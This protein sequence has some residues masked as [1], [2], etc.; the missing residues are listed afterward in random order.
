MFRI[1]T[2]ILLFLASAVN[3][4][5]NV[6]GID[7]YKNVPDEI[8]YRNSFEREKWFYEQRIF[9]NSKFPAN[10]YHNALTQKMNMLNTAGYYDREEEW[11][12]IGPTPAVNIYYGN[13]SSRIVSVKFHPSNPDIIYIAAAYGGVWKSTNGGLNWLPKTDFEVTLSSGALAID[14]TNPEIIYYGTGEA[15]YFTYSYSGSGLLKSTDGGNNWTN[16]TSGLP[17]DTYFSRL[18]IDP[19]HSNILFAAMGTGGL[20]KST[21]SGV[22]WIQ[23]ITARCD[24]VLYSPD[25]AKVYCIGQG[26]GYKISLDSGNTFNAYTPFTLGTRNHIAV[27]NALPEIMYAVSYQGT[28]ASVYKSTNGGM[29]YTLLQNNFTGA[30]QGWYDLYIHVNPVNPNIAYLG[31]IDLWRT[32]NGTTFTKLTN[33]SAG[34]VHVD[35]HNMD[36]NPLNPAQIIVA[37]DGGVYSSS[38][39]GNNWVN[40]NTDLNLTQ[41]YRVASNPAN[42]FHMVGGTQDN[43]IQQTTGSQ[44]WDVLIFGGDG[45][46]A[47]FQNVNTNFILAENQFNRIK[48]STDNGLNWAVD[49]AGLFGRAAWIAPIISHPDSAGLFYTAREKVFKSS[50]NGDNWFAYS[51]GTAGILSQLAIS[52]SEPEYIYTVSNNVV[53]LSGDGG[54]TFEYRID[55][56]P[57][58]SITSI[59]FHPDSS[60]AALVTFSGFGGGHIYKTTNYGINW[61]DVSGNLPDIPVNDGLFY[62]PGYSTNTMLAA[63]D[64][65]VFISHNFGSSWSELAAGLPNTVSIHLDYNLQQNKLRVATHGRGIWEY[66]GNIIPVTQIQTNIPKE[67]S[68]YQ[69][70]PNPFNPTTKINFSLPSADRNRQV[71]SL[72]VYDALGREV[73]TLVNQQ[74]SPGTYEVEWNASSYPSGLYFYKLSAGEYSET[75]KMIIL[76]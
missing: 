74:L 19:N 42:G 68:L 30:N 63:T 6:P 25:G 28:T 62:W 24:D 71:V 15:T 17:A 60:A 53:F 26:S 67:Y 1:I 4:Q 10:V 2:V 75:R 50:D 21:N 72:K 9:P 27:C 65:G 35:H 40:I 5:I 59:N 48:R 14:K 47:C 39:A 69:N 58:R 52:K 12:S 45:G 41:F 23:F 3:S 70:Y 76:K 33:T 54:S 11:V 13:V 37:T 61:F 46:D 32:T 36:F 49:T 20:Y 22:S 18:V 8:K 31:L 66:N 29:N 56:L 64:I 73:T 34:P 38:N 55:G 16:Y 43:G 44:I 51:T 57:V 7:I